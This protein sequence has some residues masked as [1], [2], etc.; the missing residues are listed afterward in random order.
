MYLHTHTQA[1]TYIHYALRFYVF[2]VWPLQHTALFTLGWVSGK[3]KAESG[4][5]RKR[6]A[7]NVIAKLQQLCKMR[8]DDRIPLFAAPN[9]PPPFLQLFIQPTAPPAVSWLVERPTVPPV[10]FSRLPPRNSYCWW[11]QQELI[12]TR[13]VVATSATTTTTTPTCNRRNSVWRHSW[14]T[15]WLT[16]NAVG[17]CIK[18]K[19]A[20]KPERQWGVCEC[21]G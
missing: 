1:Y 19:L 21:Y 4:R 9:R 17:K 2:F 15:D 20:I 7:A 18:I 12:I 6:G 16:Q 14:P 13:C 5:R 3:A 10:G 8:R 11:W